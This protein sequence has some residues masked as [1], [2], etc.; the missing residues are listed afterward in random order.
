VVVASQTCCHPLLAGLGP[1]AR[2]LYG[3]YFSQAMRNTDLLV[4]YHWPG[5]VR[6]LANLIQRLV[7]LR[8]SHQ[9]HEELRLRV[10]AASARRTELPNAAAQ[11]PMLSGSDDAPAGLK[12]IAR[13]AARDAERKALA[14][15]LG[16]VHW[17]R[18]EAARILRVSYKT[19][20]HKIT[21]CGLGPARGQGK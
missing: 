10:G 21:E 13:R 14:D 15:V 19:L 16:R 11:L 2:R 7:V 3:P 1:F 8:N 6:E 4:E 17:N 20:L 12:E 9:V 5:N 18:T